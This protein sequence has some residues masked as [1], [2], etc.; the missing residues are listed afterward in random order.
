M[1]FAVSNIAWDI[2]EDDVYLGLL[3]EYGISNI[4]IAP[5]KFWPNPTET[6]ELDAKNLRDKY[7]K[8]GFNLVAMQSLLFGKPELSIFGSNEVTENTLNYLKKIVQLASWLEINPLVFGSPKNRLKKDLSLMDATRRATDFFKVLG[9]YAHGMNVCVCIEANAKAYGCDFINTSNEAIN[10]VQNT[11]SAG[12]GLHLDIGNMILE[13]ENL[14]EQLTSLL[15]LAKHF[16]LSAPNLK[17]I[18]DLKDNL[19][20]TGTFKNYKNIVSLEMVIDTPRENKEQQFKM[21]LA[22]LKRLFPN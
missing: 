7:L 22:T 12:F 16:H 1:N 15:P 11:N 5:T 3:K 20:K 9:D 17:P 18:Q 21:A 14:Q 8:K 19:W 4:E 6:S 2:S 13:N 10:L